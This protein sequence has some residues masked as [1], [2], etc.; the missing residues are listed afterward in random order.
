MIYRDPLIDRA[1][2]GSVE[3][4]AA[5]DRVCRLLDLLYEREPGSAKH[6]AANVALFVAIR[7]RNRLIAEWQASR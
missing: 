3:V 1:C 2:G 7:Q 4:A 5:Q 6:D